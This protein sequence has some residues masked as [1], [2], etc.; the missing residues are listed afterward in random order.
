MRGLSLC[1]D[2]D[3]RYQFRGELLLF[4]PE[5]L[6][7]LIGDMHHGLAVVYTLFPLLDDAVVKAYAAGILLDVSLR[8]GLYQLSFQVAI[9]LF[10]RIKYVGICEHLIVLGLADGLLPDVVVLDG[11]LK[12]GS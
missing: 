10:P 9:K 5:L 12:H 7:F 4:F 11:K 3:I 6:H 8:A 2:S 1:S